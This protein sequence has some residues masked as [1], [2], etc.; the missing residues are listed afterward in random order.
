MELR[1]HPDMVSGLVDHFRK[2]KHEEQY[3][4]VGSWADPSSPVITGILKREESGEPKPA[5]TTSSGL[6]LMHKVAMEMMIAIAE[7]NGNGLDHIGFMHNHPGAFGASPSET[8]MKFIRSPKVDTIMLI[9]G[10]KNNVAEASA[11]AYIRDY[12]AV[13]RKVKL[14]QDKGVQILN[15]LIDYTEIAMHIEMHPSIRNSEPRHGGKYMFSDENGALPNILIIDEKPRLVYTV[16][17]N[18]WYYI[19]RLERK[20][21]GYV[22]EYTRVLDF[23]GGALTRPNPRFVQD[24]WDAQAEISPFIQLT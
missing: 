23:L 17:N 10:F 1:I 6:E 22:L 3:Q 9:I 8:D 15:N 13:V 21:E 7:R 19:Y 4:L 14:V 24:A 2:L 16:Q 18:D 12:D 5:M 11:T 20:G